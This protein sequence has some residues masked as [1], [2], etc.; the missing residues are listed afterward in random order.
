VA[1]EQKEY[2]IVDDN[3]SYAARYDMI[4]WISGDSI[5]PVTI[6]S[7]ADRAKL[8]VSGITKEMLNQCIINSVSRY[9]GIKDHYPWYVVC[10]KSTI[11]NKKE[12]IESFQ[13]GGVHEIVDVLFMPTKAA[14]RLSPLD[15][16]IFHLWKERCRQQGKFTTNNIISIMTREWEKITKEEIQH[17][18]HH[19]GL[20]TSKNIYFDCP[21]PIV[22]QHT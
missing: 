18:Y 17:A 22:H 5:F 19:C 9:V 20:T 11:H 10:D 2:I 13:D 14:K 1:S 8:G 3:S 4:A 12:I 21:K 16:G 6:Y 15:N 7:P